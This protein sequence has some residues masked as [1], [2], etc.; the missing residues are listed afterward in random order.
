MFSTPWT[1]PALE[2]SD[3]WSW[4]KGG[5]RF[6]PAGSTATP[7]AL[8]RDSTAT[9]YNNVP[10]GTIAAAPAPEPLKVGRPQRDR[11]K[12]KA[13]RRARRASRA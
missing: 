3:S 2:D 6:W 10:A 9:Y 8:E 4:P 5:G 11:E 7:P 13:A 12:N 1:V